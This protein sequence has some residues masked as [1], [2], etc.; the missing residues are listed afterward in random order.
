MSEETIFIERFW[1]DNK[2]LK[3]TGYYIEMPEELV[4]KPVGTKI[5]PKEYETG[6]PKNRAKVFKW[7]SRNKIKE[8]KYL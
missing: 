5:F 8:K 2:T 7:I 3:F 1:S 6:Y 4:N